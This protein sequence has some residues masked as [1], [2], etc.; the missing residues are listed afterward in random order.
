MPDDL[1]QPP[2]SG[3]K[4]WLLLTLGINK[5][6]RVKLIMVM[7]FIGLLL[8][9]CFDNRRDAVVYGKFPTFK[10][11]STRT[12]MIPFTTDET[13]LVRAEAKILLGQYD[14][15]VTD[16][17]MFTSKFIQQTTINGYTSAIL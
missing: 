13:L 6:I 17:N 15:A 1:S 3:R 10:D 4:L 7:N 5:A 9:M 11:S 8:L 2:Y 12:I 14:N 16:L